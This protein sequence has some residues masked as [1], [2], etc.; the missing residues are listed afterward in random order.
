[1]FLGVLGA[2][3]EDGVKKVGFQ[4]SKVCSSADLARGRVHRRVKAPAPPQ[5]FTHVQRLWH[6]EYK[7][8]D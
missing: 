4:Y 5:T 2:V 3:T 8:A 7:I 6:L 1:V